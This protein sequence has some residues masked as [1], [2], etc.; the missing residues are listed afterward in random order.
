MVFRHSRRPRS[1]AS[2]SVPW[3]D[4]RQV[5]EPFTSSTWP[6]PT[7]R[8]SQ[9][10]GPPTRPA[11]STRSAPPGAMTAT[12]VSGAASR[13]AR[14]PRAGSSSHASSSAPTGCGSGPT[15]ADEGPASRN[16]SSRASAPRA[17][18]LAPGAASSSSPPPPRTKPASA[19]SNAVPRS[20]PAIPSSTTSERPE[21]SAGVSGTARPRSSERQLPA[22]SR[23]RVS[24]A[25]VES[26]ASARRRNVRS[27]LR[28]DESTSTPSLP[29]ATGTATPCAS[30]SGERSPA[31]GETR[32]V[33]RAR[34]A[35][36]GT[37]RSS[38]TA[39][40]PGP[41]AA[42][43]LR[44]S[45]RPWSSS[46]TSIGVPAGSSLTTRT[47]T[48]VASPTRASLEASTPAMPRSWPAGSP[49]SRPCTGTP[50][51]RAAATGSSP[52]FTAPSV[53]RMTPSGRR[54]TGIRP[55]AASA[56]PG[57]VAERSLAPRALSARSEP[58]NAPSSTWARPR[59]PARSS[60]T[61]RSAA[62]SRVPP[63]GRSGCSMLSERSRSTSTRVPEAGSARS[64]TGIA[65][66]HASTPSEIARRTASS[67]RASSASGG[68]RNAYAHTA[69][70][71]NT[72]VARVS[73]SQGALGARCRDTGVRSAQL[74]LP[75]P[76]DEP[77]GAPRAA[78][79]WSA[80]RRP[81]RI[82][83][84]RSRSSVMSSPSTV[85]PGRNWN[86]PSRHRITWYTI[87]RSASCTAS[88]TCSREAS[89]CSTSS[90]PTRRLGSLRW[91]S[92]ARAGA[93]GLTEPLCMSS[94]PERTARP[95]VRAN[96]GRPRSYQR[97][98]RSSLR[99][100]SSR[101]E[102][103]ASWSSC[104]TSDGKKCARSP[105]S[106]VGL[107]APPGSGTPL[108][109]AHDA[110][111]LARR[112]GEQAQVVPAEHQHLEDGGREH[113]AER[114]LG[115]PGEASAERAA[116]RDQQREQRDEAGHDDAGHAPEPGGPDPDRAH[117]QVQARAAHEQDAV[118]QHRDPE[119]PRVQQLGGG[120]AGERGEVE[121]DV[122]ERV[123]HGAE[124]RGLAPASGEPAV[125][126][127]GE[128]GEHVH[129]ER[130]RKVAL[131]EEH[132]DPRDE[133]DAHEREHERQV[134]PREPVPVGVAELAHEQRHERERGQHPERGAEEET[135][136]QV[137]VP[138]QRDADGGEE[139]H[140]EV[141]DRHGPDRA[142]R[143]GVREPV[144][145]HV[146]ADP[147][148]VAEERRQREPIAPQL[149][150][151]FLDEH[152]V[153]RGDAAV[154][155]ACGAFANGRAVCAAGVR[156]GAIGDR[157][158]AWSAVGVRTGA[159]VAPDVRGRRADGRGR[160]RAD[161]EAGPR[162]RKGTR[163]DE[164]RSNQRTGLR[165][166]LA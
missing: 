8:A 161:G 165:G 43:V 135:L 10:G 102:A 80:R 101:P 92:S 95:L 74:E 73:Q 130:P 34:P 134:Q 106:V 163:A 109:V 120:Q 32:A 63:P 28:P 2:S 88:L 113:H 47:R 62:A 20:G 27:Q 37:T 91:R 156:T 22:G 149:D 77:A 116:E 61:A 148:G 126:D 137:A 136:G 122:H 24:S 127:V 141:R 143:V 86:R 51:A 118:A 133:R 54:S 79:S 70:P 138:G 114:D 112:P 129:A 125:H 6:R 71:T 152:G 83:R 3:R 151:V 41:G 14:P 58:A 21:R 33:Q 42:I 67:R 31:S 159:W 81:S 146:G 93:D 98:T 103:C 90:S 39:S 100:N 29:G 132:R 66:S 94:S 30:S 7:A 84:S 12:S 142:H 18:R 144:G 76:P 128:R 123:E 89:P 25:T 105:S 36:A 55:N 65:S 157:A 53:S 85:S 75:D 99:V 162:T 115:E 160:V 40:A 166:V 153:S 145:A 59:R 57:A 110:V 5:P 97:S 72:T 52:A 44:A 108:D 45:T 16:V 121:D 1:P 13:H 96:T 15:G 56:E 117:E 4:Q 69:S 38:A 139:R 124:R 104:R 158:T 147:A 78:R 17:N 82:S 131:H 68:E 26:P 35:R 23:T 111:R 48:G 107:I 155:A 49:T 150:Q 46:R 11:I 119:H 19:L 9:S 164:S 154:Y 64:S 50:S 140:G 87:R 60:P